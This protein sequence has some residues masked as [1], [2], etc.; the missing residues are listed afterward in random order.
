MSEPSQSIKDFVLLVCMGTKPVR[1]TI[2][3]A[4]E[5]WQYRWHPDNKWVSNNPI[6]QMDAVQDAF[7]R[8][9]PAKHA[10]LYEAGVPFKT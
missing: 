6:N 1:V 2:N 5:Y 3:E 9:L 4:G 8:R 7:A 10:L